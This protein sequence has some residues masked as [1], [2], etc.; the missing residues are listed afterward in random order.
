MKMKIECGP[1]EECAPLLHVKVFLVCH[2]YLCLF[3]YFFTINKN[4]IFFI[5]FIQIKIS[6]NLM[7]HLPEFIYIT[8][9]HV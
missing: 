8:G 2:F 4:Y 9:Y 3:I 1:H 7:M 5:T 6:I